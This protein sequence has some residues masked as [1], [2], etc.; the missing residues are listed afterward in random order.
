MKVTLI[1][2]SGEACRQSRL[3]SKPLQISFERSIG[4]LDPP[5]PLAEALG[6]LTANLLG[7]GSW[8]RRIIAGKR[9]VSRGRHGEGHGTE[10]G[11]ARRKGRHGEGEDAG[12]GMARRGLQEEGEGKEKGKLSLEVQLHLVLVCINVAWKGQQSPGFS[13]MKGCGMGMGSQTGGSP[14][15]AMIYW[16]RMVVPTVPCPP[17]FPSPLSLKGFGAPWGLPA[18]LAACKCPPMF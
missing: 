9:S 17:A 1:R 3:S 13:A 11:T 6:A 5:P 8:A 15:P 14:L 2:C 7:P 10:K 18:L 4:N 12:K 16:G